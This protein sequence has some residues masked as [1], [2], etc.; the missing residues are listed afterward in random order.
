MWGCL[1]HL[2]SQVG[3]MA[4]PGGQVSLVATQQAHPSLLILGMRPSGRACSEPLVGLA[5]CFCL[6]RLQGWGVTCDSSQVV[7]GSSLPCPT[8]T[9]HTTHTHTHTHTPALDFYERT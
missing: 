1:A 5:L 8:P 7:L 9:K 6:S 2:R 3:R 4:C